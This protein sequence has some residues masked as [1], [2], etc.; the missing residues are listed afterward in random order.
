MPP[1]AFSQTPAS[2]L[3]LPF[4]AHLEQWLGALE[5]KYLADLTFAEVSR[6]LRA[7][8]AT[9]VERRS[10]LQEGAA[11][12]GAGK[13]AAFALFYAPLHALLVHHI[14][15]A[16]EL[17]GAPVL[18]DLGC[19]T[20][21][22]GA[23]WA[24]VM[25]TPPDVLGIDRHPWAADEARA[26]YRAFQL[27]GRTKVE[28][29]ARTT[30]PAGSHVLAAFAINELPDAARTATLERLRVHASRGGRVTIVEPLARA[31]AP[32]WRTWQTRFEAAGGRAAEWRTRVPLPP[33][34]AKL[35][36]AAGLDHRE[37]TGRT[38]TI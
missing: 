29:L 22:A 24:S 12:A 20:G 23:A 18:V 6:A 19:G 3:R 38:L 35:D 33:L 9:Y 10:K 17:K 25:A 36:K 31:V 37:I 4:E 28:D 26:T 15:A 5:A 21:A 8:S 7:L 32:W 16:L 2:N 34:V 30:F 14:A 11:L 1:P 13:R 27:R